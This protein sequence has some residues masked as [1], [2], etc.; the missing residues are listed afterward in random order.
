MKLPIKHNLYKI[1]G[2][3]LG[4][5]A[6]L[7]ANPSFAQQTNNNN[8]GNA[9]GNFFGG[10]NN[11]IGSVFNFAGN[12]LGSFGQFFNSVGLGAL[13]NRLIGNLFGY[14]DCGQITGGG[15]GTVLC[16]ITNSSSHLPGFV[17]AIAY[18]LGLYFAIVALFKLKDHVS[19]PDRTMLSESMK[20]FVAGGLLF[21][22]PT[23]TS[24][25]QET[26]IGS[27]NNQIDPYDYGGFGLAADT[28][29]GGV[30]AHLIFFVADL[31]Q[32]LQIAIGAFGYLAGLVLTVVAIG[33]LIKTAQE[34]AKGPTGFGT[35]MTFITA[36]AL[37]SLDSLMGAF[38]QS[39][40]GNNIILTYPML[41]ASMATGDA[42][43]DLRIEGVFTSIV[44]FVALVGWISF[45][46]GFFI[47]RDVAE[48]NGQASLMAASTHLIAGALAVNLGPFIMAVQST[49]G[50][51]GFG[52]VFQ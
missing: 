33:R 5:A 35:I 15:L 16:N 10:V 19:N 50:L 45:I 31:W 41:G 24:A 2:L 7:S 32:P 49:F 20:R 27:G 26:I 18:L 13:W 17:V 3:F 9:I 6:F 37:F 29:G 11:A 36:G 51:P 43:V 28:S 46:R 14:Q 47:M 44:A 52:V 40:F 38:S 12:I 22:L 34:G 4:L 39:L 1:S 30:D 25:L 42:A 21:T 8:L 23:A 48:G